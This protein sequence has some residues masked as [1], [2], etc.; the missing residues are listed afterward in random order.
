LA[1]LLVAEARFRV[2]ALGA[3]GASAREQRTEPATEQRQNPAPRRA[4]TDQS[5]EIIET[6][7]IQPVSPA[8]LKADI[9]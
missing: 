8:A 5:S 1:A 9:D 6:L 7:R 2:G 4:G 3:A